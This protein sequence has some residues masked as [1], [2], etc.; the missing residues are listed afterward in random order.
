MLRI[1]GITLASLFGLLLAIVIAA[2]VVLQTPWGLQLA[3]QYSR[4]VITN[5]VSEQLGSDI[6]YDALEGKLPETLIIR[7][8]QLRQNGEVWAEFDQFTL[9]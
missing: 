6:T 9:H 7:I 3:D 8:L 2:V 4:P 5:V 1:L